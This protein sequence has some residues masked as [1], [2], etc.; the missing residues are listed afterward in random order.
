ME[1]QHV[2]NQ[3]QNPLFRINTF[4]IPIQQRSTSR[5]RTNNTNTYKSSPRQERHHSPPTCHILFAE[6]TAKMCT[7]T[8]TQM[9][10]GHVLRHYTQRC[11]TPCATLVGLVEHLDD[12][13]ARCH[14]PMVMQEINSRH[15][16]L[17]QHLLSQMREARTREAVQNLQRALEE[18]H[19]GRGKELRAASRMRWTGSVDWG[20]G[21]ETREEYY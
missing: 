15:D 4:I 2:M 12:S 10:C 1:H 19:A 16:A 3:K 18:E 5:K 14:P 17:R 13:C 20:K 7:G 11:R 9:I 8:S 6:E 21:S